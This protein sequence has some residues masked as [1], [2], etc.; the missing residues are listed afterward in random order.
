MTTRYMGCYSGSGGDEALLENL[1]LFLDSDAFAA[2]AEWGR[3]D[4]RRDLGGWGFSNHALDKL[5]S[6]FEDQYGDSM[7]S[8][9]KTGWT[10]TEPRSATKHWLDETVIW[11]EA[12]D[13]E[14]R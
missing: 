9:H 8:A 6:E 2:A 5:W 1:D 7:P 3:G 4:Y 11:L 10:D 13:R 12:V 14:S